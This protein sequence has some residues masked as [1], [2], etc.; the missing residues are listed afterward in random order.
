M[1][2]MRVV[3]MGEDLSTTQVEEA[4]QVLRRCDS[5]LNTF[6]GCT[7]IVSHHI[8]TTPGCKTDASAV[9]LGAVLTQDTSGEEHP[10]LYLSRKLFP[11][12]QAYAT[13]EK[14]AL[15]V[16]WA[17]ETL[18]YYLLGNPFKLVTDHAPLRWLQ[19]MKESNSRIMRWYLALQPYTFEVQH[20]QGTRH[21]KADFFS[22]AMEKEEEDPREGNVR[23]IRGG[24]EP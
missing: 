21:G 22:R 8:A 10:V 6:L 7:T 3:E 24:G 4:R 5:V 11:R 18:R 23:N 2:G 9:G 12:E 13:I 1:G 19:S 17:L 16:K 14:E 15:A 20:R